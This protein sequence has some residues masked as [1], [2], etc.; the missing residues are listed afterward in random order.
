MAAGPDLC[1][2]KMPLNKTLATIKRN[3][4]SVAKANGFSARVTSAYRSKAAQTKLYNR[5]LAGLQQYPVAKPGTSDHEKGLALDV[6]S[7]D[8]NK[9]VALLTAVGLTWAG[10]SD[11]V[12]FYMVA[13]SRAKKTAKTKPAGYVNIGIKSSK[14]IPLSQE[15]MDYIN[16]LPKDVR[17]YV[18]GQPNSGIEKFLID[19]F[20]GGAKT[21]V[22]LL[23]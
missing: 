2:N 17:N 19:T 21:L 1:Q 9:L 15:E 14:G 13:P 16:T 10:P 7:T 8:T 5:W 4:P 18:L 22:K 6:V 20:Y 11:P 12:H 23:F 3:L